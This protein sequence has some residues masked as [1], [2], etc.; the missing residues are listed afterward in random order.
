M[1]GGQCLSALFVKRMSLLR[2]VTHARHF[3]AHHN[4]IR[5]AWEAATGR[6]P[7]AA[8]CKSGH[9]AT[10]IR[11]ALFRSAGSPCFTPGTG[12]AQEKS[13]TPLF[14]QTP[15]NGREFRC[16]EVSFFPSSARCC[17]PC[18]I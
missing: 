15:F 2:R 17:S 7:D 16:P 5:R 14:G 11:P 3:R 12:T 4:A 10:Q 6:P 9:P 13:Y 1:L 8:P 18:C